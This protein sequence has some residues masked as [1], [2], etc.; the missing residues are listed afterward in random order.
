[1]RIKIGVLSLLLLVHGIVSGQTLQDKETRDAAIQQL[2]QKGIK[3]DEESF[4]RAVIANDLPVVNMFLAA[5]MN[6]NAQDKDGATALVHAIDEGH[7]QIA[8]SLIAKGADVNKKVASNAPLRVAAACGDVETARALLANGAEID[9]LD[10]GGHTPMLVA[11]FGTGLRS[12]PDAFVAQFISDDTMK[13][14]MDKDDG[15]ERTVRLLIDKGANVNIRATDGG[16]TPLYVAAIFGNVELVNLLLAKRVNVNSKSWQDRSV[17]KWM[18]E[19]RTLPN[20]PEIK[21][22]KVL[23]DWLG[24]TRTR[25]S[26]IVNLLK[27]AGAR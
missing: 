25:H 13:P 18:Q 23:M 12:V 27:Q 22:D 6:P 15:Y 5:G 24:A 3:L 10:K 17:M 19:L 26:E 20:D 16:E 14:C 9:S 11:L 1:M 4:I 8:L 21:D 7:R 2:A